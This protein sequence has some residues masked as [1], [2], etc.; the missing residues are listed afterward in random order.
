MN[1]LAL[2]ALTLVLAVVAIALF[3]PN[4]SPHPFAY[5]EADYMWAGKQGIWAN[6][7]DRNAIPLTEYIRRGLALGNDPSL[8][9]EFSRF[10]R[11]S[12]DLGMYRHY[13]GPVYYY[14][15]AILNHAGVSSE[16]MFRG[17]GVL[18][19]AATGFIIL[20]GFWRL[21]PRLSPWA[22]VAAAALFLFNRTA[23]VAATQVTQH[24]MFTFTAALVLFL[25]SGYARAGDR[26]W[27]WAASAALAVAVSAVETASVLFVAL[28]VTL[29]YLHWP[30]AAQWRMLLRRSLESLAAFVVGLFCIW[31]AG[32]ILLSLVKGFLMLAYIAVYRK[33]FSPIG[34]LEMFRLYIVTSPWELVFLF[35]GVVVCLW[36]VRGGV[37]HS[38]ELVP[39]LAFAGTF[40]LVL[41]K[42]TAPYTYYY[43]PLA[44]ALVVLTA[45][46]LGELGARWGAT[47][48][49]SLALATVVS[50]S[51]GAWQYYWILQELK[52]NNPYPY[53]TSSLQWVREQPSIDGRLIVPYQLVPTLHL[54]F[55]Q[56]KTTGI[57]VDWSAQRLRDT[58]RHPDSAPFLLCEAPQCAAMADLLLPNPHPLG[59]GPNHQP[60]FAAKVR[61]P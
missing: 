40:F 28:A 44:L 1:R 14:W 20:F 59:E 39:W 52:G 53:F 15:L 43:A 2:F 47:A 6:A 34:P 32:L 9:A 27:L 46:A 17:A 26:R 58:L 18:L 50:F 31:P 10:I 38:A 25:L 4:A 8:R 51:G 5:D 13:H 48:R 23:L 36:L 11:E 54:Y 56:L 3:L 61:Q 42:I 55:P 30:L 37:R 35:A 49:L 60:L 12:G 22:G 41:L 33:T 16:A 19:H 29:L 57:D 45:Y 7:T 21:F 24:G